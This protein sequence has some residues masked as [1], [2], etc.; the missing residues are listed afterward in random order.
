MKTSKTKTII[1]SSVLAIIYTIALCCFGVFGV[2]ISTWF[3]LWVPTL[4]KV[5]LSL[6]GLFV[7]IVL[8]IRIQQ[9]LELRKT[10]I[11]NYINA[12]RLEQEEAKAKKLEYAASIARE[13]NRYE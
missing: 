6:A 9:A 3:M 13:V 11:E 2:S 7:V 1:I 12:K 10:R 5:L 4:L 8:P